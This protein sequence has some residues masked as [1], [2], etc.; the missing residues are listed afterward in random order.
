MVLACRVC[1][2]VS[3]PVLNAAM[4]RTMYLF[5][6]E[7]AGRTLEDMDEYYRTNPPLLVFRDKEA[8]S[9]KRPDRFRVIEEE[10]IMKNVYNKAAQE[11]RRRQLRLSMLPSRCLHIV[12]A[13]CYSILRPC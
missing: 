9:T 12:P 7:T 1:H 4:V 13:L 5:Y 10:G 3:P 11:R 8:I 2:G 6:P